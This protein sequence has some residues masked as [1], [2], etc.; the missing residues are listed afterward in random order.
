MNIRMTNKT[1][2]SVLFIFSTNVEIRYVYMY[3]YI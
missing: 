1:Y 2:V 3:M